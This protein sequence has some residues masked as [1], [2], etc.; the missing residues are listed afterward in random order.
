MAVMPSDKPEERPGPSTSDE[1]YAWL[2]NEIVTGQLKVGDRIPSETELCERWQTS[3]GTVRQALERLILLGI[4]T[5]VR[6]SG[7]YVA[8]SSRLLEDPLLLLVLFRDH[9]L[10]ELLQFRRTLDVGAARL[11]AEMR[12]E[13]D[14]TAMHQ[15]LADMQL[16]LDG[17]GYSEADMAFHVAIARGTHNAIHMRFYQMLQIVLKQHITDLN[18]VLGA[19]SS[20]SDHKQIMGAI[21]EH[22]GVL[23]GYFMQKHLD[24]TL[25]ELY[26]VRSRET[27]VAK[28]EML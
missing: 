2:R 15:A 22:D 7:S 6:G 19:S 17:P 18:R 13:E 28:P 12:T 11:C 26:A 24:R 4:I 5:K 14:L 20:L 1:I 25:R 8:S 16:V 27:S 23:A 9:D 10:I 3:R 21:E